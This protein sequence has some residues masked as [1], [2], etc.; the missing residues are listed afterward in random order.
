MLACEAAPLARCS[1]A[2]VGGDA[3]DHHHGFTVEHSAERDRDLPLHIDD[4]E[5]TLNV[6]LGERCE[7][8]GC[9]CSAA[10]ASTLRRRPSTTTKTRPSSTR[11]APSGAVLRETAPRQGLRASRRSLR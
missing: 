10:A 11:R 9:A 6:C 7:G 1:F 2:H 3:L 4:A 8:G 5:V